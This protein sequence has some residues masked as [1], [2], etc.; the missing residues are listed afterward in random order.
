MRFP[1]RNTLHWLGKWATIRAKPTRVSPR[2]I[3]DKIYFSKA[4]NSI[5]NRI[6]FSKPLSLIQNRIYFWKVGKERRNVW[7]STNAART[8]WGNAST[9]RCS[10]S[11]SPPACPLLS[12]RLV[13]LKTL[14]PFLPTVPTFVVRETDVSRT[15]G[16]GTV[17]MNG[18]IAY[19]NQFSSKIVTRS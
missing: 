13:A 5:Q 2:S 15:A 8:C 11:R 17:G 14:N 7:S 3:P 6:Y 18:L 9:T 4:L 19:L 16:V 10:W 1:S 12:V